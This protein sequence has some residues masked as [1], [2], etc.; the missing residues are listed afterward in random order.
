M[1]RATRPGTGGT[2]GMGRATLNAVGRVA[3]S[4]TIAT[5]RPCHRC[6]YSLRGL[7][8]GTRCPECGAPIRRPRSRFADALAEAPLEY[9]RPLAAGLLVMAA[10][11]IGGAF[12][13][14][15]SRGPW[16]LYG[17]AW[18][19]VLCA[20]W[21]V[22]V[23][24]ATRPRPLTDATVPDPML[25]SRRLRT[26][27]RVSQLAWVI[28]A[29]GWLVAAYVPVVAAPALPALGPA[30]GVPPPPPAAE[31]LGRRIALVFEL[32]GFLSIVPL[33]VLLSGLADWAAESGL[34][35]RFRMSAWGVALGGLIG[36][37]ALG[38][39]GVAAP[40]LGPITFGAG[41]VAMGAAVVAQVLFIVSLVQLAYSAI[42]AI[43]NAHERVLSEER[44]ARR[45][46]REQ[47]EAQERIAA[48]DAA[49]RKAAK[50]PAD[51]GPI[52]SSEPRFTRPRGGTEP[53]RVEPE[54]PEG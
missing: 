3:V 20:A 15:Y 22:G 13:L 21:W 29:A 45:E 26:A 41:A 32:I 50:R 47:R 42:W 9:L 28:A 33:S 51:P 5:D 12:A 14:A 54:S 4:E 53:Y 6:G 18:A 40:V 1:T 34:A 7:P 30:P 2:N 43:R 49:M 8:P 19:V 36:L 48:A 38:L 25:D 44:T 27:V 10:C 35:E 31:V 23:W 37:P 52:P 11:S 46:S 39:V 17:S 16:R 24:I